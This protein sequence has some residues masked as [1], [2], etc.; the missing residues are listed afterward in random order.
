MRGEISSFFMFEITKKKFDDYGNDFRAGRKNIDNLYKKL[1]DD[2]AVASR[3]ESKFD[4]V[5]KDVFEVMR[6]LGWTG[7]DTFEVNVGGCSAT[8]TATHPDANPKWAKPYGTITYQSD[9]FIV[10]KNVNKNPVVSSQAPQ[11]PEGQ[12]KP[13]VV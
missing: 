12:G 13:V 4:Y 9:A 8:G 3:E 1:I 6:T 2:L 10:I 7:D 11:L 5:M